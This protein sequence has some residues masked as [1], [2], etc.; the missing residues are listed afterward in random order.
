MV[1]FF[2]NPLGFKST[3]GRYMHYKGLQPMCNML[4]FP[5]VAPVKFC[6]I[7]TNSPLVVCG[8]ADRSQVINQLKFSN[9]G[10]GESLDG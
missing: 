3:V 10:Q 4:Q 7:H 2:T 5:W 8:L 9:A 1:C 6:Q